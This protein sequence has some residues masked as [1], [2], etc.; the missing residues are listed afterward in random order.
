MLLPAERPGG[1][2]GQ[3]YWREGAKARQER[4]AAGIARSHGVRSD[5]DLDGEIGV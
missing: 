2:T 3:P 5:A 4:G 1:Q